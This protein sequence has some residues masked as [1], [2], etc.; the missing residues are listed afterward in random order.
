[1]KKLNILYVRVSSFE[2]NPE[3]QRVQEDQYDKVIEDRISGAVALFERPGGKELLKLITLD[4]VGSVSFWQIDRCGRDLK[5]IVDFLHFMVE[6]KIPV[7]FIEQGLSTL[8][9]DGTENPISK[10]CIA[11]MSV[12]AEMNRNLI[13]NAQREGIELA[14][15]KKNVYLGRKIGSNEDVLDFLSKSKNKAALGFLKKGYKNSEVS[16]IVGLHPNTIT[17]IKKL[18]LSSNHNRSLAESLAS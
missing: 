4:L 1:M 16:K 17:K 18:G 7:H 10:M 12:I 15:L 6:R 8:N 14:K 13:K 5:G 2:Q 3:R 9:T 11:F